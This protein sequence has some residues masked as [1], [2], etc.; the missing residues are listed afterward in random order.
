MA[1]TKTE[2]TIADEFRTAV[3]TLRQAAE[4]A[5]RNGHLTGD[6]LLRQLADPMADWLEK[7]AKD[8]SEQVIEDELECSN[9]D[10]SWPCGGHPRVLIHDDGCGGCIETGSSED[11]R[12]FDRA[13]AVARVLNGG[14]S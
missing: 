14:A 9:C 7:T 10:T 5:R 6:S 12:C 11:C 4:S 8:F 1:E 13:L 3:D 2:K